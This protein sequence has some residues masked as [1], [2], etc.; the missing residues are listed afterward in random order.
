[1]DAGNCLGTFIEV[2]AFSNLAGKVLRNPPAVRVRG[3]GSPTAL[4]FAAAPATS[5]V[6]VKFDVAS[7]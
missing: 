7:H 3:K 4:S 1:M 5:H 6:A 2:A